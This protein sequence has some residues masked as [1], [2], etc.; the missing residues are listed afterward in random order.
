MHWLPLVAMV[1]ASA[2]PFPHNSASRIAAA[3]T[4]P[5]SDSHRERRREPAVS[6]VAPPVDYS[7][8]GNASQMDYNM[9][10]ALSQHTN[11]QHLQND[12]DNVQSSVTEE[13]SNPGSYRSKSDSGRG[14][15][16]SV[17]ADVPTER[18]M[19]R[20][21]GVSTDSSLPKDYSSSTRHYSSFVDFSQQDN[22]QDSADR[23]FQVVRP[24]G[25]K[26]PHANAASAPGTES[27]RTPGG[28]RGLAEVEKTLGLDSIFEGDEMFLDAHPRV[29][30]S[31]SPSP[32]E[33]PPFL[34]MLET[35]LLEEGGDREEQE[36]MDGHFEGHGD[37]A[38]DRRAIWAELPR[39]PAEAPRPHKRDK[40]SHLFDRRRGEKSVC[41]SE[42]VWVTNKTTAID[43]HGRKVTILQEIQ[44][45]TGPL[46]QYFYETRCRQAEQQTNTSR[47][48]SPG[49]AAKPA[50]K[51]VAGAGC[52]G[53]D[54]KQWL[55]ECK[56]KQSFVRALTKDT[57]N[58]VGWR[59]IRIDSSCVCVLLSRANQAA[60]RDVQMRRGRG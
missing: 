30:F 4:E 60:G 58:R 16:N 12:K 27:R 14:V 54:K 48:R 2:L 23:P 22:L 43:S 32:P 13:T 11:R 33:H 40:R 36:D 45:Q 55:S 51:D 38:I 17:T 18:G 34:L 19:L 20:T 35:G 52:L 3:T 7:S 28:G 8:H 26:G 29:L 44:T 31:P 49:A 1:I 53:V 42:S 56:A 37:R 57:N 10:T 41:E 50:G 5:G 47:S 25:Q 21:K 6:L 59:W 9:A 39:V 24:E 15:R 46:K